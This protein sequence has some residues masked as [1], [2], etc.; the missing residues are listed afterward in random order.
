MIDVASAWQIF[1]QASI[2]AANEKTI[3][4]SPKLNHP[5]RIL[6]VNENRV[7]LMTEKAKTGAKREMLYKQFFN[8]LERLNNSNGRLAKTDM[9]KGKVLFETVMVAL[10]P[11]LR[12][13][14]SKDYILETSVPKSYKDKSPT[15]E[16]VKKTANREVT[17]RLGQQQL[18]KELLKI[19]S[20]RCCIT[21]CTI[22][23]ILSAAHII[24]Y[25]ISYDNNN[26]NALLLKSDI[27]DLYDAYLLG[28]EPSTHKIAVAEKI[29]KEYG[30]LNG[31]TLNKRNDDRSPDKKG[32]ELRWEQY[33]YNKR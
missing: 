11:M 12:W 20:G 4:L 29:E 8:S 3:F 22:D 1:L 10:L 27:H 24:P 16:N 28:I 30:W 19:Y 2:K 18:R 6:S 21:N 17:I 5:Y 7:E 25:S 31:R 26:T 13:D 9:V 15:A 14:E 32:M 23:E 33:N